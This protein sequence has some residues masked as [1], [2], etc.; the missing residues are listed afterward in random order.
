MSENVNDV[1]ANAK[2]GQA[3][4]Q[5]FADLRQ[6]RRNYADAQAEWLKARDA[7]YQAKDTM[8]AQKVAL[9]TAKETLDEY[10]WHETKL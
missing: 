2:A 10:I 5:L 1:V 4:N 8:D 9:D 7:L 3:I 6:A